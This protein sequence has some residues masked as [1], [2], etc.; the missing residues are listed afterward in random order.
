MHSEALPTHS[1]ACEFSFFL[2]L[3]RCQWNTT[4]LSLFMIWL[5]VYFKKAITLPNDY[6][7]L[8]AAV[9]VLR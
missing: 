7:E 9:K 2:V 4:V 1:E 8:H 3:G 5:I 6:E